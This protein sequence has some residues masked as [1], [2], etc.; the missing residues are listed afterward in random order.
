[1]SGGTV[2]QQGVSGAALAAA[3][4]GLQGTEKVS[5][6]LNG[7]KSPLLEDRAPSADVY[8]KPS[9]FTVIAVRFDNT[10]V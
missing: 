2:L 10:L 1:V 5:S 7:L 4:E 9:D 3:Q 8:Q 6:S